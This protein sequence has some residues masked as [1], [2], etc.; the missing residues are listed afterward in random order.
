MLDLRQVAADAAASETREVDREKLADLVQLGERM[1]QLRAELN[2][3]KQL[4]KTIRTE[5][6]RLRKEVVPEL[7]HAVGLVA[8]NGKGSFT[9]SSGKKVYLQAD[10]LVNIKKIDQERFYDWL[11]EQGHGDLVVE[12]VHWQTLRAFAKEQ[13]AE[14]SDE[15]DESSGPL[16]DY[17][18]VFPYL[19]AV[20]RKS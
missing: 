9:L 16:P 18:S 19:K 6:D 12:T 11:R 5:Y 1:D 20:I 4:E 3:A 10:M 7:M 17:V 2:D 14:A 8:A 13:L 15:P